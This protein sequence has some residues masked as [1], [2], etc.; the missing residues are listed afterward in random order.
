MPLCFSFGG[1]GAPGASQ[2]VSSGGM[3]T[4]RPAT[5]DDADAIWAILEPTIHAGETYPL[6]RDLN[7]Q[8]AL[9]Y[10]FTDDPGVSVADE[11]GQI[12]GTYHL[13][14]NQP[15][16]V[17]TSRTARLNDASGGGDGRATR[18]HCL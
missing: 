12:V 2:G 9:A 1:A 10:W 15:G 17:S 14:A 3:P 7:R 18:A 5:P 6:P 11:K 4:I 16:V 8:Q 13:M